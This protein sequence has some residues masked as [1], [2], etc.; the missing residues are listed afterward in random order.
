MEY[1]QDLY[2][3]GVYAESVYNA[4]GIADEQ[5]NQMSR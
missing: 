5:Y 2:L 1:D 3:D 4:L